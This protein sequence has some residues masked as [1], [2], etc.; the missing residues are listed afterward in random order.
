M[1][2]KKFQSSKPNVKIEEI[3]GNFTIKHC[4]LYTPPSFCHVDTPFKLNCEFNQSIG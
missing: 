2:F 3:E 1:T 4:V